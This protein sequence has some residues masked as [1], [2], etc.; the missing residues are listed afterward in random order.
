MRPTVEDRVSSFRRVDGAAWRGPARHERTGWCSKGG[1]VENRE[2]VL[3]SL[4]HRQ[5]DKIP[6]DILFTHI[7]APSHSIPADAK[8]ENIAALIEVLQ[9]Q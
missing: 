2:P 3:A 5:P 6:Y 9:S 8:P 7:A 4:S 1:A